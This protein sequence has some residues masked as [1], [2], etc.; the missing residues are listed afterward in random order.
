MRN[1][2]VRALSELI[3]KLKDEKDGR[4]AS[5]IPLLFTGRL[6]LGALAGGARRLHLTAGNLHRLRR[7][8]HINFDGLLLRL[9]RR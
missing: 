5:L 6:N 9:D 8:A 3:L 4:E 7:V 2:A 1:S